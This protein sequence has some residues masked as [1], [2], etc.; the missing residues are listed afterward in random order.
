MK[1]GGT[2]KAENQDGAKWRETAQNCL[3]LLAV[4]YL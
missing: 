2:V 1:I 3:G 4:S